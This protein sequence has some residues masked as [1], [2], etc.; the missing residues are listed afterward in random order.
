MII[1]YRRQNVNEYFAEIT[2]DA[3]IRF[4]KARY[5]AAFN[6]LATCIP[7]GERKAVEYKGCLS[8]V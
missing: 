5:N 3:E 4:L 7:F 6:Y 2:Q 1:F 8:Q